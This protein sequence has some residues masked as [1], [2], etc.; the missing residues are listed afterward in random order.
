MDMKKVSLKLV[1]FCLSF[2]NT[3]FAQEDKLEIKSLKINQV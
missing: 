1:A 3:A 2:A